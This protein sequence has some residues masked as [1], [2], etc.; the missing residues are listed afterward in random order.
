MMTSTSD[1]GQTSQMAKASV[2]WVISYQDKNIQPNVSLEHTSGPL[3][4]C[5]RNV[6]TD[7]IPS[8]YLE[9]RTSHNRLRPEKLTGVS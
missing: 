7:G 5:T 6:R 8:V 1:G 2:I 4:S 9:T 3:T